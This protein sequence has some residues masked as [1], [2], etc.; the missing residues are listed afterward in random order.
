MIFPS[1]VLAAKPALDPRQAVLVDLKDSRRSAAA[2]QAFVEPQCLGHQP[3][4]IDV[5]ER[6]YSYESNSVTDAE[7]FP[8]LCLQNGTFIP[9]TSSPKA[10]AIE[11]MPLP[12]FEPLPSS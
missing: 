7:V 2:N 11:E 12:T 4:A 10:A 1:A 9:A 6:W 5:L 3:A 8:T